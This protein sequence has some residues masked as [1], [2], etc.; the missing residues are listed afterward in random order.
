M[1]KS[2]SKNMKSTLGN[3]F[4]IS[5][6]RVR[7]VIT[8]VARVRERL[9]YDLIYHNLVF[10]LAFTQRDHMLN[11][12]FGNS[13]HLNFDWLRE[14]ASTKDSLLH[15]RICGSE[16]YIQTGH[17]AEKGLFYLLTKLITWECVYCTLYLGD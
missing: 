11:K 4:K 16:I 8:S 1:M 3:L 9:K 13:E 14:V 17:S 7:E 6:S 5:G 12:Q 15:T 2:V 10:I